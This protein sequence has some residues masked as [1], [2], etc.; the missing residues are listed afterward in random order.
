MPNKANGGNVPKPKDNRML[1]VAVG[2]GVCM[3]CRRKKANEWRIRLTEEMKNSES[4]TFVTLTF[5]QESIKELE[6]VT[7][8]QNQ[9]EIYIFAVRRFLERYRKATGKSCRHMFINELGGND[10]ERMHIHGIIFNADKGVVEKAWKYGFV[11][12]GYC[13]NGRTINYITKYIFKPDEKHEGF[14]PRVLA[15]KGIG[16]RY[17]DRN[18]WQNE[19]K[20]ERTNEIYRLPN[21][22]KMG[23]PMY[24]RQRIWDEDE[25]AELWINKLNENKRYVNGIEIDVSTIEGYKRYERLRTAAKKK[26]K[27][28]G[29]IYEDN[30]DEEN[31]RKKVKKI[32]KC[33]NNAVSLQH[34]L[35]QKNNE[36]I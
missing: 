34:N 21:G 36:E 15:S 24:Y 35:K 28:L 18:K 6:N 10:S 27:E 19:Y 20:G 25:R 1:Y 3:E 23:L 12:F 7:N 29:Y 11:D 8:S 16:R 5:D 9:E 26:E 31:Y 14:I 4:A 32:W 2:C 13:C 33:E 17:I 30:F 22:R